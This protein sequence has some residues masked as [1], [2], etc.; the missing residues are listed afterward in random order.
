MFRSWSF[1]CVCAITLS[2]RCALQALIDNNIFS[3]SMVIYTCGNNDTACAMKTPVVDS[4]W[5]LADAVDTEDVYDSTRWSE[6]G[7]FLVEFQS[8]SFWV[9]DGFELVWGPDGDFVCGDGVYD[10]GHEDCD[11]GNED[12]GESA[13]ALPFCQQWRW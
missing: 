11:D 1:P 13:R 6:S 12:D 8:D 10:A 4:T 7:I 3:D 9:H 2:R 5:T